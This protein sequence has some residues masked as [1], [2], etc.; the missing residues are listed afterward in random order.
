M[1]LLNPITRLLRGKGKAAATEAAADNAAA[2]QTPS[3][4]LLEK[5]L[6]GFGCTFTVDEDEDERRYTF[7]F[8]GGQFRIPVP[9]SNIPFATIEFPFFKTVGA[10]ALNPMRVLCNKFNCTCRVAK[11]VYTYSEADDQY[12]VH[13]FS[14][15]T[16][17]QDVEECSRL[18]R[19]L[20][21]NVFDLRRDFC[22]RLDS[23]LSAQRQEEADREADINRRINYLLLEQKMD[24]L[25]E[26]YRLRFS[27]D[28]QLTVDFVLSLMFELYNVDIAYM[29]IFNDDEQDTLFDAEQIRA[30]DIKQAQNDSFYYIYYT[31]PNNAEGVLRVVELCIHPEREDDVASYMR[32][33]AIHFPQSYDA[34]SVYSLGENNV[35]A[36][37]V[38]YAIDKACNQRYRQEYDY[39]WADAIDKVDQGR[40]DE[41]TPEQR[42]LTNA[43]VPDVG[44]YLFRGR[45]QYASGR[46]LEAVDS[47]F[48]AFAWMNDRYTELTAPQRRQFHEVCFLIGCALNEL[49]LFQQAY[50]FLDI[51]HGVDNVNYAEAYIKC[52]VQNNDFRADSAVDYMTDQMKRYR[53]RA[54]EEGEDV[55]FHIVAFEQ[56]LQCNK[57]LA[58]I[59]NDCLDEAAERCQKMLD[60]PATADFALDQLA[61]IEKVRAS[62]DD[63]EQLLGENADDGI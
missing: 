30:Y 48:H 20:L 60:H 34:H 44:F 3:H 62:R 36:V 27:P 21:L 31:D 8:Q 14:P 38:I 50:Y 4:L 57:V 43:A 53:Q 45:R 23:A 18:L 61:F 25:N 51:I 10:D 11:F 47:L 1:N 56:F 13:I 29:R 17:V 15:F 63:E 33:S 52:L 28:D 19:M 39:L 42:F 41:L 26:A 55:P 6:E 59:N 24:H 32:L 5:V 7:M 22:D 9:K 58:L 37:S 49:R 40:E 12:G 2:V 46:Y 16:F 35:D 54:E